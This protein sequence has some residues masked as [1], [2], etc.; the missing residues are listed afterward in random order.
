MVC[1]K[2]RNVTCFVGVCNSAFGIEQ[3]LQARQAAPPRRLCNL[4]EYE[5][6][7]VHTALV[8]TIRNASASFRLLSCLHNLLSNPCRRVRLPAARLSA[9]ALRMPPDPK[10][11][12]SRAAAPRAGL[13][14]LLLP[15][16]QESA[17]RRAALRLP[18]ATGLQG[19]TL[20]CTLRTPN[21]CMPPAGGITCGRWVWTQHAQQ[22]DAQERGAVRQ[23]HA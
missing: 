1:A 20:T 12:A 21:E 3:W 13:Q 19:D 2:S 5:A 8:E 23:G 17:V 11:M 7:P 18:G 9:Q 22:P 10:Q 6:L 4:L 15:L 14:Q 16:L